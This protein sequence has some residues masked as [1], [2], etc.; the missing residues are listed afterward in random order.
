M[1]QAL[2]C[3]PGLGFVHAGH[4]CSFVYDIADLYKVEITI[5]LA[6][7]LAATVDKGVIASAMRRRTRDAMVQ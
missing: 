4:E 3:S 6:F 1:I 7:E 5:P 2:G